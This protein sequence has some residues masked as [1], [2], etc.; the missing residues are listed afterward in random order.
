MNGLKRS[1][2]KREKTVSNAENI[3]LITYTDDAREETDSQP[4]EGKTSY[5][6]MECSLLLLSLTGLLLHTDYKNFLSLTFHFLFASFCSNHLNFVC[7][8]TFAVGVKLPG[9]SPT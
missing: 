5:L 9:S 6:V 4:I 8:G 2:N 7:V 3:I 1:V